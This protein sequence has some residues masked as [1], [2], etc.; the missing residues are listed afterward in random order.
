MRQ[1]GVSELSFPGATHTRYLH[2]LG[3]MELAT[4]AFDTLFSTWS[5]ADPSQAA[6]LRQIVRLAALLHDLGHAPLSHATE[7]AMPLVSE[8]GLER[9]GRPVEI[10]W[11]PTWRALLPAAQERR[12]IATDGA[13][14][15]SSMDEAL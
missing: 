14:A 1:L 12:P 4:R 2:S 5:F 10:R 15:A 7:F 11:F 6:R 9:L 13:A 3:T 8:L